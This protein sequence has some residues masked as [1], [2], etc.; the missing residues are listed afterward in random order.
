MDNTASREPSFLIRGFDS[1]LQVIVFAEALMHKADGNVIAT[2][3]ILY[4][5]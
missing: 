3:I 5:L 1:N 2:D 4:Q